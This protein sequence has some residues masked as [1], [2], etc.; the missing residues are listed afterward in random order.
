MKLKNKS[1]LPKENFFGQLHNEEISN[2]DYRH[3]QKVW[4]KFNIEHIGEYQDFFLLSYVVENNR[5]NIHK[6]YSPVF[7]G[8]YNASSLS[9]AFS[10]KKL[11]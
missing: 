6:K 7:L 2:K 5:K 8:I 11:K 9:L 4:N 10:L 3:V 1:L